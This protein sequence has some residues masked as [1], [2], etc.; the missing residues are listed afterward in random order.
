[1]KYVFFIF[2]ILV[3]ISCGTR[4]NKELQDPVFSAIQSDE[5]FDTLIINKNIAILWWPDSNDQVI[6]K[7]S[8]DEIS[9]NTFVDDLTWYT[10]RAVG[11][12][13]SIGI[14]N[15]IT[16]KDVIIFKRDDSSEVILNRKEI[17][18]NMVLLNTQKDP[19]ITNINDYRR[20]LIVDYYK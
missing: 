9:Y 1:M 16:D 5:I 20:N 13:D 10:Q 15:R 17:K 8:Y 4:K 7:R 3:F 6:M 18:G 19:M 11:M 14:E 2:V 12:L